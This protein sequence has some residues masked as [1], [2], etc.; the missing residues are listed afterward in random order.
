MVF[1]RISLAIQN[2]IQ[3]LFLFRQIV[4]STTMWNDLVVNFLSLN[5]FPAV[6]L[7]LFFY[8]NIFAFY[9]TISPSGLSQLEIILSTSRNIYL[10]L[11]CTHTHC[12]GC[13][14]MHDVFWANRIMIL[15]TLWRSLGILISQHNTDF[16]LVLGPLEP[17]TIRVIACFPYLPLQLPVLL[18]EHYQ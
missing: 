11:C 13:V 9:Y 8:L 5:S 1:Q 17:F 3:L 15:F 16:F 12:D 7:K 2:F 6:K 4:P 14:V 10:Y 18:S